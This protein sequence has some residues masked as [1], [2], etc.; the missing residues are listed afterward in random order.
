MGVS[1]G[2]SRTDNS[3]V[4]GPDWPKFE[5]LLDIMHVLHTLYMIGLKATE[6]KC[7]RQFLGTQRR[8]NL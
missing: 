3:K 2:R 4:G 1:L 6:K 7:Q 8:L 5:L